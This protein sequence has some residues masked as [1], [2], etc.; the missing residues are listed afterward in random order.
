MTV[1]E[2]IRELQ[3]HPP[4]KAV[5]VVMSTVQGQDEAGG[6][7]VSVGDDQAV[8][9]DDVRNEGPYILIRGK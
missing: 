8:E 6:F 2:L 1:D 5:R 3:R 4:S 9:A 7:T